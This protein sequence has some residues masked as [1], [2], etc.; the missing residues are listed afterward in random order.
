MTYGFP[1]RRFL[2]GGS[3]RKSC[4]TA[5]FHW[6][7]VTGRLGYSPPPVF[8]PQRV[9]EQETGVMY[10]FRFALPHQ[11]ILDLDTQEV[12]FRFEE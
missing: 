7:V 3:D 12:F 1:R 4:A 10:S 9:W 6:G 2:Q 8:F 11:P 5:V